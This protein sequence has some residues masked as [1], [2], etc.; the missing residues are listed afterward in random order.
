MKRALVLAAAFALIAAAATPVKKNAPPPQGTAATVGQWH[1]KTDQLSANLQNGQFSAPDHVLLTREDGST[2]EADRAI[3]NYRRKQA[4]LYGHVTVH[5]ASGSFG[6]SS[7]Q[8][9]QPHAAATL[10]ADEVKLDDIAHLYDAKGNVHYEQGE[11]TADAQSAHLNDVTHQLAL[12]GKVHV[13]Q[14]D[15]TLDAETATY[16]T[17]SGIGEADNNVTITFPGVTP[18]IATPKPIIIK[19]PAVP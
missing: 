17:A 9:A 3:G 10:T 19:G 13:V 6:L 11:T 18:S 1:M 7:A 8:Q 2:V 16:N 4:T 14:A 12:S 15:R 5:D